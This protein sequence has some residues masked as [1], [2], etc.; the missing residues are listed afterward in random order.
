MYQTNAT[1]FGNDYITSNWRYFT[2]KAIETGQQHWEIS[3]ISPNA[4]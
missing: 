3:A 4:K 1:K 2:V